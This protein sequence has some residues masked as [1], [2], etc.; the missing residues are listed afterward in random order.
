MV[1][2]SVG[3]GVGSLDGLAVVG[4][5]VGTLSLAVGAGLTFICDV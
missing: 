5:C 3:G 4:I 1:G 2:V